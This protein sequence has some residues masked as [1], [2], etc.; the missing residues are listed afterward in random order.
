MINQT[1]FSDNTALH[2]LQLPSRIDSITT[3]E[4]F[5]DNLSVKYNFNDEIYANV[6]TC[7]S[8]AVVNAITHGNRENPDKKVYVNLEVVEDKRLIFTV[9]D[10]GEGFDFNNIPDPTAPDNL[11][12]LTGRG[13]FII[14]RLADQCIFNSRGNELE[15][16][17]KI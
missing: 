5:I 3:L 16:H 6:L 12:N 7:L 15:L 13:V 14:K 17:F 1:E 8:E 10:E 9:S 2:T 4:N 11:E